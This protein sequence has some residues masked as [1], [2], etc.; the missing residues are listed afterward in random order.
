MNPQRPEEEMTADTRTAPTAEQLEHLRKVQDK[1]I[2]FVR[3]RLDY[4]I[5]RSSGE[6][7]E[8]F[9]PEGF[10]IFFIN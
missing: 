1:A 4:A 8:L 7:A 9:L 6:P 5:K 10:E 2:S 3:R